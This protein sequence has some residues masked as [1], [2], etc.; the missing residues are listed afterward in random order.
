MDDFIIRALLGGIAV[1]L[2]A[3]PLGSFIVWKKMAF[4]GDAVAHSA[5]LG[6]V[7]GIIL[8]IHQSISI[9]L[10]ALSFSFL[11]TI[12]NKQKILQSDTILAIATQGT[13]ALGMIA[14]AL[15]ANSNLSLT[16]LLFGDILATSYQ[17]IIIMYCGAL[18]VIAG[19]I[20]I[21]RPL[22]LTTISEDLAMVEGVNVS[23]TS[24]IF[25]LLVA[26][27]VALS[28]KIVGVLLVSSLLIIPAAIARGFSRTPEHMAILASCFGII[29]VCFGVFS[30]LKLDTPT[31]PSIV[32]AMLVIFIAVSVFKAR[33]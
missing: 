2:A 33:K 6:V 26:I 3:G 27:M 1:A 18:F 21:W 13:L 14:F 17:D 12:M 19:I 16:N 23:F 28:I 32:M 4:F 9:A 5:I 15:A 25:T 22:L 7:I 24:F 20:Y 30:S 29:S 31:G 10:F 11:L 8:G